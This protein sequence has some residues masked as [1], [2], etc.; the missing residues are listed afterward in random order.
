VNQAPAALATL[1]KVIDPARGA[2]QFANPIGSSRLVGV[3]LMITIGVTTPTAFDVVGATLLEDANDNLYQPTAANIRNCPAFNGPLVKPGKRK[4]G[5][6]T[7]DV[8]SNAKLTEL[9][10]TPNGQFGN[11]SAEWDLK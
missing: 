3:Q 6:L 1:V 4:L 9:L 2:D 11:V 7:F 10:F 8:D 5:C